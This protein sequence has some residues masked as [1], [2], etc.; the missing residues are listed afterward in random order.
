[1]LLEY[2][3]IKFLFAIVSLGLSAEFMRCNFL[4][5]INLKQIDVFISSFALFS[6]RYDDSAA[7]HSSAALPSALI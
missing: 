2:M 4:M 6:R 3:E 7:A 5:K 1:M